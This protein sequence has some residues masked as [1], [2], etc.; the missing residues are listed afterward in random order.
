[1]ETIRETTPEKVYVLG[2]SNPEIER[3]Q[4]QSL[5]LE[6]FTRRCLQDA[7]IKPGLKVLDAGCGAGDVSLIL[8][9]MVGPT[10]QV[11]GVDFNPKVLETARVRAEM[12][13]LTNLT[14]IQGDIQGDI[15][16]IIPD[17]DF[18]ALAGRLILFHLKDKIGALK[19]LINHVRPGGLVVFQDYDLTVI[20]TYPDSDLFNA[21][22]YRMN[23][24]FRR[25]GAEP[26]MG[27][28]LAGIFMEAG[29]PCP[30]LRC[31]ASLGADAAWLGFD[32][33]EM[34]TR[35]ILPLIERFGLATAEE[36]DVDTLGARIRAEVLAGHGTARGPDLV[37]AWSFKPK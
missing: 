21:T 36:L 12:A 19:M 27:M 24:A 7:G 1:M 3:L 26:Q 10:G 20:K 11:V 30:S 9:E 15:Q 4:K 13:G 2:H 14:F 34:V 28:R 17:T 16:E 31:E 29:L 33:I 32:Q 5:F 25:G 8:A 37:S 6:A 18:D 22:A 23:E 35:T